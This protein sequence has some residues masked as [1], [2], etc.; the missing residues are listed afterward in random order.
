MLLDIDTGFFGYIHRFWAHGLMSLDSIF[1]THM[2]SR[3][4]SIKGLL[5][6]FLEV[7]FLFK[8][9]FSKIFFN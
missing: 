6:K 1:Y 9:V 4:I 8:C 3:F 7:F 2:I 5:N